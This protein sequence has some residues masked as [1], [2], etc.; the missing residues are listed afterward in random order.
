MACPGEVE[1]TNRGHESKDKI[2]RERRR[3]SPE[4]NGPFADVPS[5]YSGL[6][7][8][9]KKRHSGQVGLCF[10]RSNLGNG[11]G[12]RRQLPYNPICCLALPESGDH[13]FRQIEP[14]QRGVWGRG[15][16][17]VLSLRGST[18]RKKPNT[19]GRPKIVSGLTVQSWQTCSSWQLGARSKI[20]R[21]TKDVGRGPRVWH[22]P[23]PIGS[24]LDIC[25]QKNNKT[26]TH[27]PTQ[28]PNLQNPPQTHTPHKN[29]KKKHTTPR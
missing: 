7:Y 14:H 9:L 19:K 1:S 21:K 18:I 2:G 15:G 11:P 22:S 26:K 25:N 27:H 4:S 12:K 13:L 5:M 24:K 17:F 6:D 10:S 8:R 28:N 3:V 23:N 20:N 16:L 29:P